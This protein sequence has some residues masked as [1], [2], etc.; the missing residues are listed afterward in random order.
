MAPITSTNGGGE[1]ILFHLYL[2]DV[3]E[4]TRILDNISAPFRKRSVFSGSGVKHHWL[5]SSAILWKSSPFEAER[6][7]VWAVSFPY[8]MTSRDNV[9]KNLE[10]VLP[11]LKPKWEEWA[12]RFRP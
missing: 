6:W 8:P 10:S 11:L 7:G 5:P 4:I 1:E 12:Q 3:E 9:R 2:D